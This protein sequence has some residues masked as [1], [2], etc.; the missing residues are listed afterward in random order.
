MALIDDDERMYITTPSGLELY[1]YFYGLPLEELEMFP[2]RGPH[3]EFGNDP[4]TEQVMEVRDHILRCRAEQSRLE[5]IY[6]DEVLEQMSEDDLGDLMCNLLKNWP[7]PVVAGRMKK[8]LALVWAR[9][10][11]EPDPIITKED[12]KLLRQF[13]ATRRKYARQQRW[14]TFCQKLHLRKK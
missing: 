5:A 13:R 9:H 12:H 14:H 6:T 7:T 4:V 2:Q 1:A 10:Q 3:D 8:I 11:L